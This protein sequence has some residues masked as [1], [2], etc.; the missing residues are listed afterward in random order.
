MIRYPTA[1]GAIQVDGGAYVSLFFFSLSIITLV[2]FVSTYIHKSVHK[3]IQNLSTIGR[4]AR[5]LRNSV[6]RFWT[7]QSIENNVLITSETP[8][9]C[10]WDHLLSG[11]HKLSFKSHWKSTVLPFSQKALKRKSML[12]NEKINVL[13]KKTLVPEH[14]LEGI[15]RL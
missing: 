15:N 10:A 4:N 3:I 1:T 14:S 12:R 6:Q 11:L 13:I 2:S 5:R 9:D 7:L 8:W